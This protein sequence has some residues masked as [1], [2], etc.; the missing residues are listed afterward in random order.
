MA[1]QNGDE[2]RTK[3][4][5]PGGILGPDRVGKGQKGVVYDVSM[6]SGKYSVRF[7]SGTKREDLTDDDIE[8]YTRWW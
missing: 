3:R 1:F 5:L 8:A 6:W 2:A 7:D 4:E